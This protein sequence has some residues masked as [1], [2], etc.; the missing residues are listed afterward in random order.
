ML[1]ALL[2]QEQCL[3]RKPWRSLEPGQEIGITSRTPCCVGSTKPEVSARHQLLPSNDQFSLLNPW[4][5]K[6][7]NSKA[8]TWLLRRFDL[9]RFL[10][11]IKN[12]SIPVQC[13]TMSSQKAFS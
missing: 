2:G 11:S 1:K 6:F 3:G 7:K 12:E 8:M 4:S 10:H 9:R 13:L 5:N